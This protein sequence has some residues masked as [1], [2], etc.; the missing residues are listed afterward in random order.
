MDNMTIVIGRVK[1]SRIEEI[2]FLPCVFSWENGNVEGCKFP[3]FCWEKKNER[4]KNVIGIN[5]LSCPKN[6]RL[7]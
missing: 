5:L 1:T 4:M 6:Y 3:L 7:I 2:Y